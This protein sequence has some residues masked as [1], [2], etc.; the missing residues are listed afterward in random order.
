MLRDPK[1]LALFRKGETEAFEAL[2]EKYS[3][4]IR[5][6]LQGGF[7]F[8][9]QGRLCR[10]RGA[11]PSMDVDALIQETFSRAFAKNTRENYDGVR[12]FQTYLFSIA[13]NLVLRECHHRERVITVDHLDSTNDGQDV[14]SQGRQNSLGESPEKKVANNQLKAITQSFVNSLNDEEKTFFSIRFAKGFTQEASALKMGTTRARIK[15]LEKNVRLRFLDDLRSN[16]Y[17]VNYE[18][19]PRWKRKSAHEQ[20][21]LRAVG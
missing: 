13:K 3:G 4:P 14:F 17:F 10:F 20:E 1:L 15:L 16:G 6:F 9:S 19:N 12:P 2:Y 7:S 11:D 21:T 5:R 18:P 8:S